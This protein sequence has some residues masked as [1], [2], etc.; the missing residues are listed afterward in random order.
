MVGL[1]VGLGVVWIMFVAFI[2]WLDRKYKENA[3]EEVRKI[4]Q[5]TEQMD[6][7]MKAYLEY[8][9]KRHPRYFWS[10]DEV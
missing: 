5:D 1:L 9:D 6:R 2:F 7:Q 10:D 3:F 8:L 4:N